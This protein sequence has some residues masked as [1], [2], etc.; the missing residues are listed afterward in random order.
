M[1]SGSPDLAKLPL[2]PAS[3]PVDAI[4]GRI[5]VTTNLFGQQYMLKDF[6]DIAVPVDSALADAKQGA[7]YA[8]PGANRVT[9]PCGSVSVTQVPGWLRKSV[10]NLAPAP[11]VTCWHLTETTDA[12]W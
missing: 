10:G 4:A 5:A 9:V 1:V 8:G 12:V 7:L 2:L 6:G 3:M 11:P